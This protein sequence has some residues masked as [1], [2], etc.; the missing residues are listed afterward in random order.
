MIQSKDT[1]HIFDK[2]KSLIMIELLVVCDIHANYN[3]IIHTH[4]HILTFPG[5]DVRISHVSEV[6]LC[7][8]GVCSYSHF[9]FNHSINL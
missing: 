9:N 3:T 7:G 6:G 5:D 2:L 4:V 1:I 8:G